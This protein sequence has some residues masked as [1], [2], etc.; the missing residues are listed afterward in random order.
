M[1]SKQ[2]F[3]GENLIRFGID[4]RLEPRLEPLFFEGSLEP[5]GFENTP[6]LIERSRHREVL[7]VIGEDAD[8]PPLRFGEH[9]TQQR[10]EATWLSNAFRGYEVSGT[11][12]QN[13]VLSE[14]FFQQNPHVLG[15][16]QKVKTGPLA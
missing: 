12:K 1:Q 2:A 10:D 5:A 6:P 8:G 11:L 9:L 14:H 13:A 15:S 3:V 4:D 16:R 7:P